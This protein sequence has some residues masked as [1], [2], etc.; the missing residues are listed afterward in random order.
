[1]LGFSGSSLG[2]SL[3][4]VLPVLG[5]KLGKTQPSSR[6]HPFPFTVTIN[7]FFMQ[8]ELLGTTELAAPSF[9]ARTQ[10][11]RALNECACQVSKLF[12]R[13]SDKSAHMHEAEKQKA[14]SMELKEAERLGR[15][16]L[17]AAKA[18]TQRL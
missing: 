1:M 2:S 18:E 14:G 16:I 17:Q 10:W 3:R 5:A 6:S 7:P 13:T 4:I 8:S 9:E 12:R 15:V 11:M